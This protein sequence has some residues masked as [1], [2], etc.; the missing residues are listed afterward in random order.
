MRVTL[1]LA[2]SSA[3]SLWPVHIYLPAT[4]DLVM[5]QEQVRG[6]FPLEYLFCLVLCQIV[7]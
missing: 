1:N 5:N 3:G 7:P 4:G 6:H 2:K